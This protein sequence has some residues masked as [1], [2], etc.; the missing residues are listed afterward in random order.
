MK[1]KKILDEILL[2]ERFL[3]LRSSDEMEQYL[4]TVWEILQNTYKDIGGFKSSTKDSLI[5]ETSMWKL[6]RRDGKIVAV[7][8][9]VNKR[10]TKLVG[11]GTDGSPAGKKDMYMIISED[12]KFKRVWA[13]VS[14]AIE[15]IYLKLGAT[16]VPNDM[17]A[18]ILN[19]QILSLNPD[20]YHYTRLIKGH[21]HEKMIV[22]TVK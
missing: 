3:N 20:G 7:V 10:G 16:K 17:A 2:T 9:Y 1:L 15:H 4:D 8:L 19:K 12:I 11:A 6:S 21:P 22:G 13:E 14:G 5:K 18:E